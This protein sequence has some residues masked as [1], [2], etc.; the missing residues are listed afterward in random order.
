M[1]TQMLN[2][3]TTN[4]INEST[5]DCETNTKNTVNMS[6]TAPSSCT[7]DVGAITV[8]QSS[9]DKIA[10]IQQSFNTNNIQQTVDA[11]MDTKMKDDDDGVGS[12]LSNLTGGTHSEQVNNI[13]T[14]IKANLTNL[15][16]QS[17]IHY[18]NN[19]YTFNADFCGKIAPID[20]KQTSDVVLTCQQLT[21]TQNDSVQKAIASITAVKDSEV[22]G[23]FTALESLF[24]S[25]WFVVAVV[26]IV[27][28]GA[29][30]YYNKS[31]AKAAD[32]EDGMG[33]PDDTLM[34]EDTNVLVDKN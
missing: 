6:F 33:G 2:E 8:S 5:Q 13:K 32:D 15:T 11:Y 25:V 24:K 22:A 9:M 20:I 19:A 28:A 26:A 21:K 16:N 10:C 17:C 31:T 4:V 3:T 23:P 34:G 30:Y 18:T 29:L 1:V 27:I 14:V 7:L 12:F